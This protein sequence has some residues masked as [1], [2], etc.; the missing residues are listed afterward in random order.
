M[1]EEKYAYVHD[2]KSKNSTARSARSRRTHCGKGGSVR[3]PSD[4]LTKKEIKEMSGDVKTYRLNEPMTWAEFKGM[5]EDLQKAYLQA[6]RKRY[7]APFSEIAKMLGVCQQTLSGYIKCLGISPGM[8]AAKKLWDKEGFLAWCNGE[9]S[10]TPTADAQTDKTDSECV[11]TE[12]HKSTQKSHESGEKESGKRANLHLQSGELSFTGAADQAL[13]L[14]AEM[15]C[16]AD[17]EI[18]I[19]WKMVRNEVQHG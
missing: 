4:Y 9:S 14:V 17:V 6:I 3:L 16:G 13:N 11:Y 1:T 2:L 15:L 8:G 19:M 18:K 5:P 7:D 12:E 10:S